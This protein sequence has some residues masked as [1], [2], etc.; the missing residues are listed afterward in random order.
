LRPLYTSSRGTSRKRVAGW[1]A[2][3][4]AP[5]AA[6]AAVEAANADSV[7]SGERSSVSRARCSFSCCRSCGSR[8]PEG[9]GESRVETCSGHC[10]RQREATAAAQQRG[11]GWRRA[12][13]AAATSA[14]THGVGTLP[15]TRQRSSAI[16]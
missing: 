4:P 1:L 3:Q 8:G 5:R 2:S 15:R 7:R 10:A 11:D 9:A 16:P 13:A 12:L 14:Q 6:E